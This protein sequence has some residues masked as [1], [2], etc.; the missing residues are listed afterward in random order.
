VTLVYRD[1]K[2]YPSNYYID[3]AVIGGQSRNQAEQTLAARSG[4]QKWCLKFPDKMLTLSAADYGIELDKRATMQKIDGILKGRKGLS[5][6]LKHSVIRGRKNNIAV[7]YSCNRDVLYNRLNKLQEK[8]NRPAVNARILYNKGLLEYIPQQNGYILDLDAT[9]SRICTAFHKGY[10]E[11]VDAAIINLYP[12]VKIE[13][14]KSV[15]DVIGA[16]AAVGLSEAVVQQ[17]EPL[18]GTIIMPGQIFSFHIQGSEAPPGMETAFNAVSKACEE[19]GLTILSP[20]SDKQISIQNKLPDPVL[21]SFALCDK[22]IQVKVLGCQTEPGK[23]IHLTTEEQ[24]IPPQVKLKVDKSLQPQERMIKQQGKP[25]T[26]VRTYRLVTV[27]DKLVEKTLLA[28]ELRPGKDTIIYQ[29]PN[30]PDK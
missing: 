12:A 15:K 13:D 10:K 3:G 25:G 2:T 29:G 8:I 6:I 14:I 4:I 18:N 16:Y 24:E 17:T 28:Q 26:M 19:A 22:T 23:K 5:G 20:P 9:V 1:G 27:N 11:P 7:V 30:A 21:L